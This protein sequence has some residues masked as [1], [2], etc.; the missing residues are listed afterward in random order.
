M[1]GSPGAVSF[2]TLQPGVVTLRLQGEF[3]ACTAPALR[4]VLLRAC[5]LR[6]AELV[7]CLE[8][9][10]FVDAVTLGLL[11][12]ATTRL[13]ATD[14]SVRFRAPV[15]GRPV[16]MREG[17]EPAALPGFRLPAPAPRQPAPEDL[18]D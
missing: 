4:E 3:D 7:I 6:P 1:A 11:A 5:Q 2:E 13:S 15:V 8:G 14:C 17:L 9:V 16:L 10:T 18:P 12:G